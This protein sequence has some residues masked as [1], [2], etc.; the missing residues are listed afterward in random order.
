[1]CLRALG[2]VLFFSFFFNLMLQYSYNTMFLLSLDLAQTG[3]DNTVLIQFHIFSVGPR[4]YNERGGG[5]RELRMSCYTIE[6][7]IDRLNTHT[8][9]NRHSEKERKATANNRMSGPDVRGNGNQISTGWRNINGFALL[10][11]QYLV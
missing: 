9:T 7:K 2:F 5:H 1:M 6:K 3:R 11:L 10:L 8:H 4:R